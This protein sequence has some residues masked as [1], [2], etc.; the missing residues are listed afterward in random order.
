MRGNVTLRVAVSE[1]DVV[2]LSVT[3]SVV[4]FYFGYLVRT[5]YKNGFRPWMLE[6]SIVTMGWFPPCV[7]GN[8][9]RYVLGVRI[10]RALYHLQKVVLLALIVFLGFYIQNVFNSDPGRFRRVFGAYCIVIYSMILFRTLLLWKANIW[11]IVPA[12]YPQFGAASRFRRRITGSRVI[13]YKPERVLKIELAISLFLCLA[14]M[15]IGNVVVVLPIH[16]IQPQFAADVGKSI[17]AKHEALRC[18]WLC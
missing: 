15:T 4:V 9:R 18:R 8:L 12:L 5:S 16:G 6:S 2:G 13:E 1:A 3:L 17:E 14:I 7:E 10:Y 11:T